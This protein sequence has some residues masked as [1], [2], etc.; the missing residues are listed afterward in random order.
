MRYLV[1]RERRV[2]FGPARVGAKVVGE[3]G[4]FE[5]VG[6]GVEDVLIEG[7]VCRVVE[8]EVSREEDVGQLI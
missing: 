2:D 5:G 4:S 7:D 8:G 3:W 1:R 6:F